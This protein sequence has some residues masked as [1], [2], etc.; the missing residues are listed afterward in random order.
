MAEAGNKER[1]GGCSGGG[2]YRGEAYI[3]LH[4]IVALML[5]ANRKAGGPESVTG[6]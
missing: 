4:C 5:T 3:A 2:K 1:A 6:K